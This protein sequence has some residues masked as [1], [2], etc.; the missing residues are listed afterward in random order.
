MTQKTSFVGGIVSFTAVIILS[1]LSQGM[2]EGGSFF[3]QMLAPALEE[4]VDGLEGADTLDP[5]ACRSPSFTLL[6]TICH[7]HPH[8][9]GSIYVLSR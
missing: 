6:T 2:V 4:S 9:G 1:C 3:Q 8:V 5:R 7:T